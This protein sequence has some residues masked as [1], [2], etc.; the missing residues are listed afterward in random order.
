MSQCRCYND[1]KKNG[2]K[3]KK[4]HFLQQLVLDGRRVA[5]RSVRV[6]TARVNDARAAAR[7]GSACSFYEAALV[8]RAARCSST[9]DV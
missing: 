5:V 2:E 3:N 6:G 4:F 1:I 8:R 9:V 7:R